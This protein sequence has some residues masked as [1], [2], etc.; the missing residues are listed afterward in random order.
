M[1]SRV[2]FLYHKGERINKFINHHPSSIN[3]KYAKALE[4]K[5]NEATIKLHELQKELDS[6]KVKGE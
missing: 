2:K 6:L 4:D 1:T 5:V 3:N